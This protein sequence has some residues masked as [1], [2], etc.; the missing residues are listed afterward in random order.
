MRYFVEI[1]DLYFIRYL[2]ETTDYIAWY[3]LQEHLIILHEILWRN[4]W[5]YF[6]ANFTETSDYTSWDILQKYLIIIKLHW[7]NMWLYFTTYFGKK[8]WLNFKAKLRK[9]LIIHYAILCGNIWLYIMPYLAGTSDYT[10]WRTLRKPDYT[11]CHT[12]RK[13]LIIH[14]DI[15]CGNVWL[16]FMNYLRKTFNCNL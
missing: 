6:T 15:L 4:I 1:S 10:L 7:R 5:L 14:Y 13:R 11:L 12:L 2:A 16:Y 8:F 9:H 3:D